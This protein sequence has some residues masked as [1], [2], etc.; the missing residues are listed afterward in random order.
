MTQKRSLDESHVYHMSHGALCR[1]LWDVSCHV[2]RHVTELASVSR[3]V[4]HACCSPRCSRR[5]ASLCWLA[6]IMA[7][8][9]PVPAGTPAAAALV[10]RGPD[11]DIVSVV[12][13][14]FQIMVSA[15]CGERPWAIGQRTACRL[16][17]NLRAVSQDSLHP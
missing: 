14:N 13:T 4:T 17:H 16:F 6:E 3:G 10:L 7:D 12:G 8:F 5:S 11:P 2:L 15:N 1:E 9:T